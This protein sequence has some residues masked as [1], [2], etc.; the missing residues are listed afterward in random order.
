MLQDI[1]IGGTDTTSSAIDWAMAELMR[2]PRIMVKAQAEVRDAVKGKRTI[3]ESD[4]EELSY[5]KLVISETLRLH[6]P[7]PLLPRISRDKCEI[8]GY[9]L[10]VNTGI[11]I[12]AWALGR[13]PEYWQDPES[14]EPERFKNTCLDFTGSSM[15]YLPFG[16]GRRMCPG[17]NFGLANIMFP[18]AQLLY[19]FNWNLPNGMKPEQLDMSEGLGL[20]NTRKENLYVVASATSHLPTNA[21]INHQR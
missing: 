13:D 10:P 16:A 21:L 15:E 7:A 1:F 14:F 4:V 17:I 6:T 5:L 18:L 9:V 8:G 2:N 3:D 11:L 12:N 20:G 19:H